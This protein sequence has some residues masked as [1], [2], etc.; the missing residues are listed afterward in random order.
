MS[1]DDIDTYDTS[2]FVDGV[3]QRTSKKQYAKAKTQPKA[4]HT[5]KV[6][7]KSYNRLND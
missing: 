2:I 6:E 3:F 4:Q 5:K 1:F 7:N